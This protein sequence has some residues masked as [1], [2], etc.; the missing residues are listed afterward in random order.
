[1]QKEG[2]A[3]DIRGNGGNILETRQ[4]PVLGEYDVVVLG[5]G[6]SGIAAAAAAARAGRSTLL[7]ERYGFL[8]GSGTAACISDFCGLHANVFGEHQQVVHGIADEILERLKR[9]RGL[10]EPHLS[11]RNMIKAQVYDLSA[12]KIAL[13]ELML[14]SGVKLLFHTL[15]VG[16]SMGADNAIE[17]LFVESK[18]GRAAIRGRVFIDCSGDGDIAAWSGAPFEYGDGLGNTLYPSMKFRIN[19]VDPVR[20]RDGRAL[21]P[22]LMDEAEARGRKFPRKGALIRPQINAIEW[23]ANATLVKNPDGTAVDGTNVEQMTYG[24][25]EGRRQSWEIFEFIREVTPGFENAYIVDIAPQLG[26]RQTRRILGEYMLTESDILGCADFSDSIGVNGWPVEAHTASNVVIK[27]AG[28]P[29]TRGFNQ[30]P[31]RMIVPKKVDNLL[32]A[33][34][35][36]SMTYDGQSSARVSGPCLVMGQAAGTAA[37]LALRSGVA[38]RSVD[39]AALQRALEAAGAYLGHQ[40][41]AA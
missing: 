33:G 28:C 31:Y 19:N 17:A 25:I 40:L 18:S 4:T 9:L 11:L 5:G 23:V 2:V 15:A 13:D 41:Q 37:D 21:L 29:D 12:Y 3:M 26:I 36:A 27:F 7:I 38:P 24:E 32:V 30:M 14:A 16:V 39:I 34:R 6:P 8:G 1:M 35:C 22:K 20:A 10:K